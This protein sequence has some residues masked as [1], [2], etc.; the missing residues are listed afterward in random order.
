MIKPKIPR[1]QGP[2]LMKKPF[3]IADNDPM[4]VVEY[5]TLVG[6]TAATL[7]AI[8]V[9]FPA[10]LRAM[11]MWL[12]VGTDRFEVWRILRKGDAAERRGQLERVM[13]RKM[14]WTLWATGVN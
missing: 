12:R 13:R 3:I 1:H 2:F 10:R 9:L 4:D 8:E 6:A 5:M 7:T 11:R 14:R